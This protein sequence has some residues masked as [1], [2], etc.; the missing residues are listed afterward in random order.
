MQ[1]EIAPIDPAD[2]TTIEAALGVLRDAMATDAPG[3]PPPCPYGFRGRLTHPTSSM[4][5]EYA[6]ARLDG[7]VAGVF[8][9]HLPMRDNLENAEVDLMVHPAYRRRG[10]GRALQAYLVDRLRE[11]DRKRYT[12]F[13]RTGGP[14][15]LFAAGLGAK[16]AQEEVR[17]RLDLT[18]VDEAM[19]SALA[20]AA[21]EKAAGYRLVS[22]RDRTPDEYV[23]D[24]AYLVGRFN[25]DAPMGDLQ[26]E[27]EQLDSSRIREQ[28]EANAASQVRVYSSG[29]VHVESG[30][31]V[32]LTTIGRNRSTPWHAF[33]WITLVDRAHRGNRLGALVKVGNLRFAREREPEL[34]TIDTWNAAVNAHMIAINEEMGFRQVD[35]W[36]NWQHEI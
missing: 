27:P 2:D 18:T 31:M 35:S 33:Q 19:L 17:R 5:R 1:P 34:T 13:A 32:A 4:R 8:E 16:L 12:S 7:T 9:L 15:D 3:F 14:G 6:V 25:S 20:Q 21:G 22:F 23:A 30:R 28:E 36:S 24:V 10:V 29:A 11:L 26:V